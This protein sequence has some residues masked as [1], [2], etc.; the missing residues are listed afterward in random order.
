MEQLR[1]GNLI[2]L[3]TGTTNTRMILWQNGEEKGTYKAEVGVR[4]T[5]IDG[6]NARLKEAIRA[7]FAQLLGNAGLQPADVDAVLAS[8]MITSEVGLKEVPHLAAPVSV[9]DLAENMTTVLIEDVFP[10][11]ISFIP[12][13]K[14]TASPVNTGN[15]EAMDI[16]RGEETEAVC[17][18]SQLQTENGCVVVLP[19]SHSKFVH[20]N[21]KNEITGCLTSLAGELLS[22]LTC[23]TILADSV[24][25]HFTAPEEYDPEKVRLGFETARDVGVARA[26][27]SGRILSR[28]AGFTAADLSN[29]LLGVA[30]SG[31]AQALRN[32]SALPTTPETTIVVCGK[33]PLRSALMDILR[34]DGHY[35]DIRAFDLQDAVPLSARGALH[36]YSLRKEK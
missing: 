34:W 17:I 31:D 26:A 27:F 30:L 7:G 18:L 19:G 20:I 28:F 3:D 9:Q 23:N 22:V 6:S 33:E 1:N 32:S 35:T 15:F 4:D 12:G 36:L 13:V 29:Y 24:Q 25:K 2:T 11:P 10:V 21:E 16:M 8:G 5:S 14:N